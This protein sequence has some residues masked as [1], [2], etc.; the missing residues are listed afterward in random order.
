[1]WELPKIPQWRPD[2]KMGETYLVDHGALENGTDYYASLLGIQLRGLHLSEGITRYKFTVETSYINLE[3]SLME[4]DAPVYGD[5]DTAPITSSTDQITSGVLTYISND[6]L[7]KEFTDLP[8]NLNYITR[9]EYL[10]GEH[11]E[12][13]WSPIQCTMGTIW[14]ETE[15]H[16][17]PSPS[18]RSCYAY[19]QRRVKGGVSPYGLPR[20][21]TKNPGALKQ[22]V[23]VWPEA[24]SDAMVNKP[25]ATEN[26][27]MGEDR[28]YAGQGYKNW[29]DLDIDKFPTEISRRFT[30]AFN[31]FWDATLNPL[32][33]TNMM[34]HTLQV[35]NKAYEDQ[36]NGRPFMN[37]TTGTMTITHEVY[38]ASQLWVGILLTTTLFLQILAIL[39]L[40][41]EVLIVGPDVLGYAS[42]FTRD[43]PYVPL[44][45][46]GSGLGGP[47]RARAL[48]DLR[49]QLADVR[50]D[51]D[52]GYLA[53]RAIQPKADV[54]AAGRDST[55]LTNADGVSEE[56]VLK[57]LESKR[58]YR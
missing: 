25:S 12:D 29:T 44:Q 8:I 1:M 49:L 42:S 45:P 11:I 30:T 6:L 7:K 2:K 35:D 18:A 38:R 47:E 34:S 58:L 51:E 5:F 27:I 14:I 23:S 15:I 57:K 3:C 17:G 52:I 37:S 20:L 50:P 24:S 56:T 10:I 31:T 21:M 19:Q 40:I 43:N 4:V 32:G 53:V 13:I 39:G 22:A 41:L 26:Y 36:F 28:P 46:G 9:W 48:R 33:H 16:C 54:G 55:E